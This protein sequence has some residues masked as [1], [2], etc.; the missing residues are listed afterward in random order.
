[1]DVPYAPWRNQNNRYE[2]MSCKNRPRVEWLYLVNGR[3]Q[4]DKSGPHLFSE[5]PFHHDRHI[6]A[7]EDGA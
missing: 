1:M 3:G 5:I 6:H 4:K 2:I 7:T